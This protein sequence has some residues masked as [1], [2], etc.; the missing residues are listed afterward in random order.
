MFG[1]LHELSACEVQL[2]ISNTQF[3]Q[4]AEHEGFE[5]NSG[6][7]PE[8]PKKKK[9]NPFASMSP[10][11]QVQHF[12]TI[13]TEIPEL[14]FKKG[15]DKCTQIMEVPAGL[16]IFMAHLKDAK[17]FMHRKS[18]GGFMNALANLK[19]TRRFSMHKGFCVL[20]VCHE[21]FQPCWNLHN[22]CALVFPHLEWKFWDLCHNCVEVLNLLHGAHRSKWVGLLLLWGLRPPTT[23]VLKTF[24]FGLLHE[25]SAC[26]VQLSWSGYWHLP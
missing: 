21:Y 5:H 6:Q 20:Q 22:L 11:Q 12:N 14:P 24:R 2:T 15:K 8:A 13:M 26:E 25:L 4:Q 23:V 19:P 18:S 10:M 7:W 16:K 9:P 3:V 17:T 1:L